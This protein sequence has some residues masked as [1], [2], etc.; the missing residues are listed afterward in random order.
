MNESMPKGWGERRREFLLSLSAGQK[1]ALA[2]AILVTSPVWIVVAAVFW[3]M[4]GWIEIIEETIL[5]VRDPA[6]ASRT[7]GSNPPP[8][9]ALPRWPPPPPT[10]PG[11][12]RVKDG[13]IPELPPLH[14]EYATA[15]LETVPTPML[16]F[17]PECSEQHIDEVEPMKGC[18]WCGK[19][20]PESD[21]CDPPADIC[22]HTRERWTNPP[23]R[24]HK[25]EH[26]GWVWRISD[27]PTRGVATLLTRGRDDQSADPLAFWRRKEQEKSGKG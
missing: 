6:R 27:F 7:P 23:H 15:K 9:Q 17:C 10:P 8:P 19:L 12:R 21:P 13:E 24:S 25:C 1:R 14:E 3:A 5:S 16:I 2:L 26:C 20:V 4:K 18:P 11:P 22:S